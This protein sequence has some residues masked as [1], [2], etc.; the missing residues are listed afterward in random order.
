MQVSFSKKLSK[1]YEKLNKFYEKLSKFYE[2]G[3]DIFLCR[4]AACH[5]STLYP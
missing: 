4:D 5:V 3:E 2:N 1:F